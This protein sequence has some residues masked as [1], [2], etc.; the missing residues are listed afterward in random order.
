MPCIDPGR[1]GRSEKPPGP[2][3]AVASIAYRCAAGEARPSGGQTIRPSASGMRRFRN[4][5]ENIIQLPMAA[6]V[7]DLM[8]AFVQTRHIKL[9]L[10][11]NDQNRMSSR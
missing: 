6:A 10:A 11:R 5:R 3:A 8:T 9:G 2:V 4:N 7:G 1:A